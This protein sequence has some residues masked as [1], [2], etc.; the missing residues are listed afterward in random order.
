MIRYDLFMINK[1]QPPVFVNS[2]SHLLP[3][4]NRLS[5]VLKLEPNVQMQ[6]DYHPYYIFLFHFHS[7]R[8]SDISFPIIII[9]TDSSNISNTPHQQN[10]TR[11]SA[12]PLLDGH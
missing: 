6:N 5:L 12:P 4:P 3:P 9:I 11:S 1:P 10:A 2:T 7:Y 8:N